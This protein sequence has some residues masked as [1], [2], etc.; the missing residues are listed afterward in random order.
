MNLA[1]V[2]VILNA[3]FYT[4]YG[5]FG[6]FMP[7]PM[8]GLLGWTPDLL[9]LHQIRAISMAM[10]TMGALAWMTSL[11]RTDHTPLVLTFIALTLAFAAGRF[12]GLILDGTGP[13][14][15]YGEIAFELVWS[16]VGYIALRK[17]RTSN[18]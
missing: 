15:T 6:A 3:V 18:A 4:V 5:L 10:A 9:G 16:S 14:Q 8:A 17:S 1:K 2:F 7:H 12:L 13:S 11:K